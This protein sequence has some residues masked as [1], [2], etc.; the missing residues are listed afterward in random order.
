[1]SAFMA[2]LVPAGGAH[3][4][5]AGNT[6]L[7]VHMLGVYLLDTLEVIMHNEPFVPCPSSPQPTLNPLL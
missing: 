4:A 1:M 5:H 3:N 7:D 2:V 6:T